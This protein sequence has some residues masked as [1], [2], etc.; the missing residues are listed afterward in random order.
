MN[1]SGICFF[2]ES[3]LSP[4]LGVVLL[5]EFCLGL[6]G[7]CVVIWIFFSRIH[8]WNT[9]TLYLFN[10]SL[11]DFLLIVCLPFRAEYFLDGKNWHF[12]DIPCRIMHFMISLNRT[13]SILFLTVVVV[14]RY[15][16]I[17]HPHSR[18]NNIKTMPGGLLITVLLWTII[19][20]LTAYILSTSHLIQGEIANTTLCESF[21]LNWYESAIIIW[22]YVFFVV[23]LV[24]PLFIILLCTVCII[25][26]LRRCK[27][28]R[29]KMK[30]TIKAMT[31]VAFIF[32]ICFVPSTVSTIT[33]V[34]AKH[35]TTC[36]LFDISSLVFAASLA[37]TYLNSVL[38]PVAIYI[39]SPVFQDILRNSCNF[40][41]RKDKTI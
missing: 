22:H 23:Q 2:K 41:G 29:G 31:F 21:N 8:S 13:G 32:I 1:S 16:M 28:Q 36:T 27:D 40:T 11:A 25:R 17:V 33:V 38:N 12:G 15:F 19:I 14:N 39:S 34:I 3:E 5:V 18:I 35:L 9:S 4:V 7:N 6:C 20:T 10:V 26:Q 24:I 30:R 37:L